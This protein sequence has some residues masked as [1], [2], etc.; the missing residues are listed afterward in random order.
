MQPTHRSLFRVAAVAALFSALT[1]APA[2]GRGAGLELREQGAASISR[3]DAVTARFDHP[4]TVY[5]NPAGMAFLEGLQFSAGVTLVFPK[6]GYSDP[7]GALEDSENTN[8]VLPPPHFYASWRINEMWAVGLSVNLPF[9]LA[10]E[11]PDDFAGTHIAKRAEMNVI[12]INPNVAIRPLD[13][14][15]IAVG[16]QLVPG[17]VN[18]QRRMGFA[19]AGGALEAGGVELGG[20]GFGVGGNLGLMVRPLDWLFLGFFYRSR[21]QMEFEG[22]AHFTVPDSLRDRSVFHDQAAKA[23]ATLPDY[24]CFGIG[25]Q[26]A[27]DWYLEADLDVVV[28]STI[29]TIDIEFPDDES[30]QLSEKIRE[31]WSTI[32]TPR[33]GLEWSALN[34]P[35]VLK[36]RA[37]LGFDM[38]PAP[39]HTLSPMLPDSE[40]VYG[41]VGLG[42]TYEPIGLGLDVG[43]MY[44]HFLPRTVESTDCSGEGEDRYCNPFPAEYNSRALLLGIDLNWRA[45]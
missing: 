10:I 34:G 4:S 35:H 16:V 30:G 39:D 2:P 19:G 23:S 24:M 41:S 43:F 14:L 37:G 45:F 17:T 13:G 12:L 40:R 6:F 27:E 44:S 20:L 18:I 7:D 28:W 36:V 31:D 22:D 15:A 3:S 5:F 32:V 25:F 11:W 21:V 33:L 26:V 8:P 9:G 38:N 29:Q 42:W 1:L